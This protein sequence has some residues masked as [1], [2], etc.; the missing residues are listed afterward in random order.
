MV[1]ELE[2]SSFLTKFKRLC[3]AGL[4]ASLKL[5]CKN[6]QTSVSLDVVLGPLQST[7]NA[8][9]NTSSPSAVKQRR[10]RSPAYY[11]RQE[12]RRAAAKQP[13]NNDSTVEADEVDIVMSD[14]E[15]DEAD[16][17]FNENAIVTEE[18]LDDTI[19]EDENELEYEADND[20]GL[21]LEQLINE[22]K[23]KRD[24]W[25]KFKGSPP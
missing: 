25:D 13:T 16:E 6:G 18:S 20:I 19:E 9:T 15:L 5:N 17:V 4:E 24:V 10:K 8:T 21:E 2:L 23:R 12:L 3:N 11:R 22:S 1:T 14:E 7:L